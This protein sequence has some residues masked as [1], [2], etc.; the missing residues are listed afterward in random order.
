MA[1]LVELQRHLG[2]IQEIYS[3]INDL[4]SISRTST[5]PR[6]VDISAA[7]NKAATVFVLA[8]GKGSIE[9]LNEC[10]SDN[11]ILQR[12]HFLANHYAR[13]ELTNADMLGLQPSLDLLQ[14]TYDSI[15]LVL[16]YSREFTE[17]GLIATG[18]PCQ[19]NVVSVA[20]NKTAMAFVSVFE[21]DTIEQLFR[22][23]PDNQILQR[24]YFLANQYLCSETCCTHAYL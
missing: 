12:A 1:N 6:L 10:V 18:G 21:K 3:S 13:K 9:R 14:M 19:K 16:G 17:L 22:C 8:L 24:A 20:E 2:F 15:N 7:D 23:I 11:K 4:L 5:E